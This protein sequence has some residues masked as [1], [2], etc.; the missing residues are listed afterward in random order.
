MSVA[1]TSGVRVEVEPQF[2]P[3]QSD[4]SEGLWVYAYHVTITNESARTVQLLSRHWIITN[5]E[6]TEEHVKGPGVVGETPVLR[7]GQAFRYTSGCPLGT[8]IG[9]MHGTFQMRDE[10]GARFDVEIAPFTLA[11]PGSLN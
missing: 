2:L 11:E 7:P 1:V 3:D 9:A 8:P 5:A 10:A 4:P 6:G